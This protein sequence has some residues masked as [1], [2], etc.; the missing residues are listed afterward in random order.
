MFTVNEYYSGQVKSIGFQTASQPATIGVM[1]PGEYT[2][3]T[4]CLETMTV[5]SGQL[6]VQ[7]PGVQSWQTFVVGDSFEV[8]AQQKFTLRVAENSA[9]LCTYT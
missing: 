3:S 8:A 7:L 9:Y 6:T 5:I 1:A 2:F 4:D